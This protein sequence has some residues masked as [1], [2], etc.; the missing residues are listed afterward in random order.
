MHPDCSSDCTCSKRGYQRAY[1]EA[2]E[3]VFR[4]P[5]GALKRTL[6]LRAN[7]GRR[8]PP[9]PRVGDDPNYKEALAY[10]TGP[11]LSYKALEA[12]IMLSGT[13]G[14]VEERLTQALQGIDKTSES[15]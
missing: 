1:L 6:T 15:L 7:G 2:A 10:L 12:K 13:S 4:L 11:P 3:L 14:T 5:P 8:L 9:T